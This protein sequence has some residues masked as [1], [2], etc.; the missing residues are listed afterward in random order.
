MSTNYEDRIAVSVTTA[1]TMTLIE[2]VR[3]QVVVGVVGAFATAE[4]AVSA[5]RR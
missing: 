1:E 5:L 3:R 4:S 2:T